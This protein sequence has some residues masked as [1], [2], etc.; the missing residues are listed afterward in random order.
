[1]TKNSNGRQNKSSRKKQPYNINPDELAYMVH[2]DGNEKKKGTRLSCN[3]RVLLAK[4]V[5]LSQDEPCFAS[6]DYLAE[7]IAVE[8][9]QI[10]YLLTD[11]ERDG[12][13][14]KKGRGTG[15]RIFPTERTW[16]IWRACFPEKESAVQCT[17]YGGEN[18]KVQSIAQRKCSTVHKESAIYCTHN[19]KGN[20]KEN[21]ICA[22]DDLREHTPSHSTS[23]TKK[24]E[25]DKEELFSQFWAVYP[26]KKDKARAHD[27]F[28]RI[29]NLPAVFPK[30][31][32]ALAQQ[33]KSRQ[34][35]DMQFVPY[36]KTWINGERW[37][38]EP[39]EKPPVPSSSSGVRRPTVG[40]ET[41]AQRRARA[42]AGLQEL[43]ELHALN[44]TERQ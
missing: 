30:I 26:K 2:A 12:L 25:T 9:R 32:Q 7:Y 27:K 14:V 1:M 18:E 3:H 15:R 42:A 11:L 16:R 35:Q 36:A 20:S 22:N 29:K 23:K 8:K 43:K 38:D 31:M 34:W 37:N 28:I 19:N 17:Y 33:K 10:M 44:E 41:E 40:N 5:G 6:N 39:D 4:I 24:E 21:S 13:I